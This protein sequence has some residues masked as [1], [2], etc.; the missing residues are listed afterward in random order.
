MIVHLSYARSFL[1]FLTYSLEKKTLYIILKS[2]YFIFKYRVNLIIVHFCDYEQLY[3]PFW[4]V[5]QLHHLVN[6][7]HNHQPHSCTRIYSNG[8]LIIFFKIQTYCKC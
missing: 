7:S 3:H 4:L 2:G 1:P 5:L 8:F 6:N